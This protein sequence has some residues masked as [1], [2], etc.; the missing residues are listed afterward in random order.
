MKTIAEL[1]DH[2]ESVESDANLGVD[3]IAAPE[4]VKSTLNFQEF[5]GRFLSTTPVGVLNDDFEGERVT[6]SVE[7]EELGV[8]HLHMLYLDDPESTWV[9]AEFDF[10][11]EL[12]RNQLEP[13]ECSWQQI[14]DVVRVLPEAHRE[15]FKE[16]STRSSELSDALVANGIIES[17]PSPR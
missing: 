8:A 17:M 11:N 3:D 5:D 16:L 15:K 6:W 4:D 13:Y 2:R 12:G 9:W 7:F 14:A 1:Q 10:A